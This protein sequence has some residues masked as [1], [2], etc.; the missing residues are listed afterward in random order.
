M[1]QVLEKL[2]LWFAAPLA[3]G[4]VKALETGS[5]DDGIDAALEAASNKRAQAAIPE[6]RIK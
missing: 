3:E 5:I 2:L 6:L 1:M 4:A